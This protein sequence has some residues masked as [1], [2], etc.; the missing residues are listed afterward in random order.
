MKNSLSEVCELPLADTFTVTHGAQ[1]LPEQE[2]INQIATHFRAIM[3]TLGLDMTDDSLQNTPDRVAKMFVTETFQGLSPD[4][5][6]KVSLFQNTSGYAEMLVERDIDVYS[7]CEHHFLPF[8]GKAHVAYMPGSK[9]IG[10]S[11]INRIVKYF[12]RR[13]QLQERLTMEIADCLK[14]LLQTDDVA[15]WIEA[16]HLCVASRGTED[17]NSA[18]VTSYF[19]GRFND[20]GSK[21][22]FLAALH[23]KAC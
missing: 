3:E 2:K 23:L 18:T 11:K 14:D 16:R 19:G 9:I 8:I 7:C 10:L 6:P 22:A 17:T 20:S 15:I 4:S 21:E 1:A 5:F 13:P 12:C